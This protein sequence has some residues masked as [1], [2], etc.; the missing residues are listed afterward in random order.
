MSNR[1]AIWCH[2]LQEWIAAFSTN[3]TDHVHIIAVVVFLCDFSVMAVLSKEY[4]SCT[5]FV[6]LLN[7]FQMLSVKFKKPV[8][9]VK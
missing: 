4:V 3:F 7:T 1:L 6:H 2:A 9:L 8:Q 5:Y